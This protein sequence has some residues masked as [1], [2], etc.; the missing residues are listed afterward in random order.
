MRHSTLWEE[1]LQDSAVGKYVWY[2]G[3]LVELIGVGGELKI[4]TGKWR[5]LVYE[6]TLDGVALNKEE[7][8]SEYPEWFI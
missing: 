8:I 2:D 3:K 6:E 5:T 4:P 7:A 1:Q